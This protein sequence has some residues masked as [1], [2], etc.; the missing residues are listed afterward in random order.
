MSLHAP[1]QKAG[2]ESLTSALLRCSC[3]QGSRGALAALEAEMKWAVI[4][5]GQQEGVGFLWQSW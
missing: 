1:P 3:T 4:F 2:A 5:A